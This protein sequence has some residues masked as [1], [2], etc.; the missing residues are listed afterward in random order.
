MCQQRFFCAFGDKSFSKEAEDFINTTNKL[1]AFHWHN[2]PAHLR[3]TKKKKCVWRHMKKIKICR[4]WQRCYTKYD[5]LELLTLL[6]K[7]NASVYWSLCFQLLGIFSVWTTCN[8]R[9]LSFFEY[10]KHFFIF[11]LFCINFF[12]F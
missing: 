4:V 8:N 7:P 6:S 12:P 5:D 3:R 2:F 1:S 9:V 10:G 11:L